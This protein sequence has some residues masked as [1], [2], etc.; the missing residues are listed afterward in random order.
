MKF[1]PRKVDETG[2]EKLLCGQSTY[3]T[4]LKK[5][6]PALNRKRSFPGIFLFIF[7]VEEKEPKKNFEERNLEKNTKNYLFKHFLVRKTFRE[8]L[9]RIQELALQL[10]MRG[11]L[12]Q[13]ISRLNFSSTELK[14]SSSLISSF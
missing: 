7:L 2:T 3:L 9:I 6:S 10:K 13:T 11:C 4:V 14:L 1:Y 12:H 5:S 8:N